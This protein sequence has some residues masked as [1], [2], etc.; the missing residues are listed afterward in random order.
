MEKT[1]N[2]AMHGKHGL[3]IWQYHMLRVEHEP[4]R[5]DLIL[6][7]IK[8]VNHW[9]IAVLFITTN[10]SRSACLRRTET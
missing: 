7:Q 6:F 10:A 4:T 9:A 8:R 3:T 5:E 1:N 2:V